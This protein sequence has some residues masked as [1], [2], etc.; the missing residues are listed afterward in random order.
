MKLERNK[1]YM[2]LLVILFVVLV[3]PAQRARSDDGLSIL[4]SNDDGFNAPGLQALVEAL[5]PIGKLV[6]AA[7]VTDQS[8][9]G[10]GLTFREPILVHPIELV[11]GVKGFAIEARPATCVWLGLESLM[12]RKPDLVISGINGGSNLGTVTFYSGTVGGARQA[13]LLG[14]PAIAV[15]MEGNNPAD[16]A[17][18]AVFIRE[19]VK[20]LRTHRLLRPGLFLNVNIPPG[21]KH[22]V[23]I[24]RLSNKAGRGIYKRRTN[25][26]GQ[27][28]FWS[29]FEPP[30]DRN[31][32]TDVGAFARGFITVTPLRI[33]QTDQDALGS[34]RGLG[35]QDFDFIKK[36]AP[37]QEGL[38]QQK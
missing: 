24:V 38:K 1:L 15:S 26:Y 9:T 4:I 32:D 31:Q 23:R 16:Y 34:L 28:Y 5:I 35:L 29:Q 11:P 30:S 21:W 3:H 12:K 37:F 6:I 13:A 22:G 27:L 17:T 19:L 14:I 8:G 25:P 20:Q 7:P 2:V 33:D 18:A 36:H 10:H